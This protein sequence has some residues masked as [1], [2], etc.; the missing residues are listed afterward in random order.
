MVLESTS[1]IRET[2]AKC[3][4]SALATGGLGSIPSSAVLY[5]ED[6]INP[7]P[8]VCLARPRQGPQ[9]LSKKEAKP[10]VVFGPEEH[11]IQGPRQKLGTRRR[12]VKPRVYIHASLSSSTSS[13]SRLGLPHLMLTRHV[14]G[15][16]D[17]A[18]EG[19]RLV[20]G[21]QGGWETNH[22]TES[23]TRKRTPM[24]QQLKIKFFVMHISLY[25]SPKTM[26]G[27]PRTPENRVSANH[28]VPPCSRPSRPLPIAYS[29]GTDRQNVSVTFRQRRE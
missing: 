9:E 15:T 13:T 17:T 7:G 12:S 21:C 2:S 19:G 24:W 26:R 6:M 25:L 11:P 3:F 18:L 5:L 14:P 16:R 23:G 28:P 22:R 27:S 10:G 4:P 29:S 1:T 20:Y 8:Q